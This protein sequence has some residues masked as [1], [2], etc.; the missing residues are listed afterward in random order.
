M[1]VVVIVA[2]GLH[3]GYVGCYG[4]DWVG[5]PALDR[6]AAESVVFDQHYADQPDAAG[7]RRAWRTGCYD[8]PDPAAPTSVPKPAAVDLLRT[9]RQQGIHT[10]LVHDGQNCVPG[11]TADWDDV[12]TV[13][14]SED[15][16][17][18]T[19]IGESVR[20]SLKR[21]DK[22]EHWLLW[23]ELTTLLP[24]WRIPESY[25]AMPDHDLDAALSAGHREEEPVIS[26]D[27]N[28][29]ED[30]AEDEEDDLDEDQEDDAADDSAEED[31][32]EA[33]EEDESLLPL[34]DPVAGFLPDDDDTLARL[35]ETYASAVRYLDDIVRIVLEEVERHSGDEPLI[36]LTSDRGVALGEHGIVLDHR[37]WLH[38]ELIHAPLIVRL[39]DGAEAGRRISALTQPIDLLPTLLDAFAIRPPVAHAPGSPIGN[40]D[41]RSLWPLLHGSEQPVREHA[42]IGLRIGEA[43]ELAMR[44]PE[45]AFLL[46][47]KTTDADPPRNPRLYVKP[48]DRW[49]VNDVIQHH[50]E[51]AEHLEILLRGFMKKSKGV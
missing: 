51:V 30:Q 2:N 33:L 16:D 46:P 1:K 32:I 25:F 41:G 39:P 47:V 28:D 11:F 36:V 48:E 38:D 37:P 43:I 5:T 42:Y 34:T 9:L 26:D 35:Q 10:C 19:V 29:P 22:A 31:S 50:P 15:S 18:V 27:D 21:V 14:L 20:S 49:E 13:Q 23:L 40:V 44:T 8:L 7:A 45:W 12:L 4:N 3:L 6:L 17:V 24:P